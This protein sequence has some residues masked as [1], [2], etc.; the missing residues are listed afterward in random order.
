MFQWSGL[1]VRRSLPFGLIL[2][3]WL[4][5]AACTA[6]LRAQETENP[7]AGTVQGKVLDEDGVPVE[8]ARV[9]YSSS[10]T[11][12]RGVTRAGKDGA[13]VTEQLSPGPYLVHVE[14]RDMLPAETTV[15]VTA[16]ASATAES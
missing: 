11:D 4:T 13:Y 6:S 2:I 16:G 8:G 5:F 1:C 14:G 7:N 12:T 15:N 3:A 9:S 10:A